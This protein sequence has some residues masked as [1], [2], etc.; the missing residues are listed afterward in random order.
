MYFL[1]FQFFSIMIKWTIRSLCL[2]WL[3][4]DLA[5]SSLFILGRLFHIFRM[6]VL[7]E[8]VIWLVFGNYRNRDSGSYI[9]YLAV[10]KIEFCH[11]RHI[12][13]LC[14]FLKRMNSICLDSILNMKWLLDTSTQ[15]PVLFYPIVFYGPVHLVSCSFLFSIVSRM[16]INLKFL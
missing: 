13:G 5:L 10:C 3:S 1:I 8:R 12:S 4:H 6:Y 15:L 7:I 2:W 16:F 14:K 9:V 11:G